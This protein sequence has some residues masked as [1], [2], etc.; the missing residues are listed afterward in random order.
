MVT[1]AFS[2][3]G[4][5][6]ERPIFYAKHAT[7]VWFCGGHTEKWPLLNSLSLRTQTDVN[8]KQGKLLENLHRDTF[9][10]IISRGEGTGYLAHDYQNTTSATLSAI[11]N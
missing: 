8:I 4:W 2:L 9:S 3:A 10:S 1:A 6:G 7:F 11:A 5:F